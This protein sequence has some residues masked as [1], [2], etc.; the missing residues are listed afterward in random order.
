MLNLH[1]DIS[2][3]DGNSMRTNVY[4]YTDREREKSCIDVSYTNFDKMDG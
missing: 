1:N 2:D 4:T 3:T